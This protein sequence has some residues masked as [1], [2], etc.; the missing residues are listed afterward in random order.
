VRA[1]RRTLRATARAKQSSRML[2]TKTSEKTLEEQ[3]AIWK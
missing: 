1:E 2:G 3:I